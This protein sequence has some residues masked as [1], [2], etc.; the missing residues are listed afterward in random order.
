M[1]NVIKSTTSHVLLSKFF[2]YPLTTS[3]SK[4]HVL[5]SNSLGLFSTVCMCMSVEPATGAWVVSQGYIA[6]RTVSPT[7]PKQSTVSSYSDRGG[8]CSELLFV[9]QVTV[10][11]CVQL[12]H[13]VQQILCLENNLLLSF[14]QMDWAGQFYCQLD[15]TYCPKPAGVRILNDKWRKLGLEIKKIRNKEAKVIVES[16]RSCIS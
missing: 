10:G 2:S 1:Y 8:S 15:I 16:K 13:H 5:F 14:C 6:E 3:L 4:L 12:Y 11:S 7:Q 9:I